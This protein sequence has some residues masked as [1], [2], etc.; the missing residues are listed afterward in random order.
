[1][2][3]PRILVFPDGGPAIGGGHILRCLTLAQSLAEQGADLETAEDLA[4]LQLDLIRRS[5]LRGL[6][7][8]ST[9]RG[10]PCSSLRRTTATKL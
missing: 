10:F 6:S 7:M 5:G 2:A 8:P 9:A 1:M 4:E 3:R